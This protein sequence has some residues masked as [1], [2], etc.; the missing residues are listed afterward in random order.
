MHGDRLKIAS[1]L[2][3]IIQRTLTF[4]ATN[5]KFFCKFFLL[6]PPGMKIVLAAL[7]YSMLLFYTSEVNSTDENT[8][9]PSE[10]RYANQIQLVD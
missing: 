10:M 7:L 8:L 6:T 2:I 5:P 1:S 9:T 4:A 3:L